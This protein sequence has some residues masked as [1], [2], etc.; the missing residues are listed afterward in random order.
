[1]I[2]DK[3]PSSLSQPRHIHRK[4][5]RLCPIWK[6]IRL[7]FVYD[8]TT[9][10]SLL[11]ELVLILCVFDFLKI[12]INEISN[13]LI[14]EKC[15]FK[16]FAYLA[17]LRVKFQVNRNSLLLTCQSLHL[18][19]ISSVAVVCRRV[20]D[21]VLWSLH[22]RWNICENG[23]QHRRNNF[24]VSLAV[25]TVGEYSKSEN[26]LYSLSNFVVLMVKS[27]TAVFVLRQLRSID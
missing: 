8:S 24:S 5:F 11:V 2:P 4:P 17:Q 7:Q 14:N 10:W 25:H 18:Q 6:K 13:F 15:F 12:I 22:R 26:N 27:L 20:P 21:R 23:Q 1:M 19:S 16:P 3:V 9:I